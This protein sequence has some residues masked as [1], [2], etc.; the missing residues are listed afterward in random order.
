MIATECELDH[1]LKKEDEEER[2]VE[3]LDLLSV[4]KGGIGV[5]E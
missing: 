4:Q 2:L 1:R 5:D 3:R